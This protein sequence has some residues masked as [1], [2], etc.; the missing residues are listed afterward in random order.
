MGVAYLMSYLKERGIDAEMLDLSLKYSEKENRII[1]CI[2][3]YKP[4]LIGISLYS[5]IFT[6]GIKIVNFIKKN[7]S[8]PIVAGGPHVSCTKEDFL[9][10]APADYAIT[11]EGERPLYNLI[12]NL[13]IDNKNNKENQ[14]NTLYNT[15]GIIFRNN[16]GEFIINENRELIEDI[17]TIPYPDYFS[18]GIKTYL[19]YHSKTYCRIITSRGCPYACSYCAVSICTGRKF[20]MRKT[21]NVVDE[22]QYWF[23]RGFK[24]FSISDGSF[25][26]DL[27][28]AKEICA[29]ILNRKLKINFYF[30]EGIRADKIDGELV[31]LFKKAGCAFIVYGMESGN[32]LILKST[33]KGLTKEALLN[34]V[35]LTNKAGIACAVNF[36]L[37]LPGETYQTAMDTINF[38]KSLKCSY[39]NIYSFVP[40]PGTK[41]YEAVK[42]NAR[43]FYDK[44]YYLTYISR[45]R[46]EPIFETTEFKKEE[47][48]KLYLIGN[49]LYKKTFFQYKF[50]K[51]IGFII[52]ILLYNEKIFNFALYAIEKARW[53][54]RLY[55]KIRKV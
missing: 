24:H 2:N 5:N 47:R 12:K 51:I 43:F 30:Y 21:K 52:Y 35:K 26:E 11:K 37:G 36:I 38:A 9:K 45:M 27:P 41:A 40:V 6:E 23:E 25:N 1:S 8:I 14:M 7:F 15:Q 18:C 4:D 42:K 44:E 10:S 55:F 28:R 20:R 32:E 34:A 50:G 29:E 53:D 3:D 31:N 46:V 49:R 48:K 39:V 19:G 16:N 17:D 13:F 22:M 54:Y 33:G